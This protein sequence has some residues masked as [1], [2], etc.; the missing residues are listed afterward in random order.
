MNYV[1][2]AYFEGAE[3]VNAERKKRKGDTEKKCKAGINFRPDVLYRNWWEYDNFSPDNWNPQSNRPNAILLV[4]CA[5]VCNVLR[6]S[7]IADKKSPNMARRNEYQKYTRLTWLKVVFHRQIGHTLH[8][9]N[10][11]Q[12]HFTENVAVLMQ[13]LYCQ[14][15]TFAIS[16]TNFARVEA[17]ERP[18]RQ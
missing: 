9:T 15:V 4:C 7:R 6:W 13:L 18:R 3:S 14:L 16:P 2:Y 17:K 1:E 12:E 11:K 10:E 5:H 8:W